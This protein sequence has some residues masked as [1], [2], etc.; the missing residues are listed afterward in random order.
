MSCGCIPA[1]LAVGYLENHRSQ[2][3][4]ETM[5]RTHARSSF[6]SVKPD[7]DSRIPDTDSRIRH[8]FLI[9]IAFALVSHPSLLLSPSIMESSPGAPA[10][11]RADR[12][13]LP[14]R[15][16]ALSTRADWR[17][18]EAQQS[19]LVAVIFDLI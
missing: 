16:A 19:L 12:A 13:A 14:L 2:P 4:S 10:G 6:L 15:G 11:Q 3:V 5:S 9:L 17:W 1:L 18:K 8:R 7:T